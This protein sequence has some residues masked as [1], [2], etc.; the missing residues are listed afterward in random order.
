[1]GRPDVHRLAADAEGAAGEE[2]VVAA[3]LLLD[4]AAHQGVAL[5]PPAALQPHHHARIGVHRADAVDAGDRRHDH[6]VAPLQQRLRRRVAHA[7]DLLVD[8]RVLLY[9]GVG[10]RDV[11]FRLV[12][13]VVGNEVL[14]RVLR[15]ERLHL[16][17]ELRGQGLVRRQDQGRA[18]HRLDHLGHGE[19]LARAG[20][21]EQHLVALVP[22]QPGHQLADGAVAGRRSARRARRPRS[23]AAAGGE[24][25]RGGKNWTGVI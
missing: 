17:V 12:V 5:D 14:H 16:A 1:M 2:A 9:V 19:G 25:R 23:A 20:D 4:E 21:A 11:G 13:V 18:L 3:V 7:V 8:L 22:L 15:E 24:G 10:A 6:H